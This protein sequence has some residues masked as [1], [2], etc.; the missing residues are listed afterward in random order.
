MIWSN[1][2]SM[3]TIKLLRKLGSLYRALPVKPRLIYN[4]C[5]KIR[6][7]RDRN[8]IVVK[9]IDGIKYELHLNEL[10]D[11]EIYYYGCFEEDTTQTIK[12][13]VRSGMTVLDIGAHSLDGKESG[14]A[15]P[16]HSF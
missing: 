6:K 13:I 7:I 16:G 15:R 11:S 12:S 5:F 14:A 4:L 8:R 9:M 3:I 2:F 10:I 1:I